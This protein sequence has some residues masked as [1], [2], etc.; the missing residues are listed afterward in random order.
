[1]LTSEI[2]SHITRS[3]GCETV[4]LRKG[5]EMKHKMLAKKIENIGIKVSD[6]GMNRYEAVGKQTVTWV[7]QGDEV[8]CLRVPSKQTNSS[9]DEFH[10]LYLS[11][12][13]S[14]LNYLAYGL[15]I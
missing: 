4:S 9:F 1:V 15:W 14:A 10:D 11:T 3:W 2:V 5:N 8:V 13:K 7:K 12:I 6:I